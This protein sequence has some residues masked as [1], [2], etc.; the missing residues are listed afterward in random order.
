[1][2]FFCQLHDAASSF[3]SLQTAC[4]NGRHHLRWVDTL[5]VALLPPL[6][7]FGSIPLESQLRKLNSKHTTFHLYV[8]SRFPSLNPIFEEKFEATPW[9]Q[10]QSLL[11]SDPAAGLFL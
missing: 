11:V 5:F 4:I 10:W 2:L 6:W 8:F 9:F 3:I 1:M 7:R